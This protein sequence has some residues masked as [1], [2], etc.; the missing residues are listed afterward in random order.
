MK[1]NLKYFK[2]YE[3]RYSYTHIIDEENEFHIAS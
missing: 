2:C 1:L 3:V